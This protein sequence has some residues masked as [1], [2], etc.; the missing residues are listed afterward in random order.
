MSIAILAEPMAIATLTIRAPL[1]SL[2]S[3]RPA[4][5][6][7]SARIRSTLRPMTSEMLC[8]S[9]RLRGLADSAMGV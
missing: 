3:S 6:R 5:G 4:S 8:E 7:K 9:T 2:V 1:S